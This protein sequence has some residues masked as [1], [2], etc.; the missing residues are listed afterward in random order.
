M[1]G[2]MLFTHAEYRGFSEGSTSKGN[3]FYR[4][5]FENPDNGTSNGFFFGDDLAMNASIPVHKL[6]KGKI[7]TLTFSY[8]LNRY[9]NVFQLRL[10]DIDESMQ[11]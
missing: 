2:F 7:Y 8:S 6:E 1:D 11:P 9:D 4:L 3:H 10:V 5:N